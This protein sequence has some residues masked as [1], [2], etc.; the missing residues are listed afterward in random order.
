MHLRRAVLVSLLLSGFLAG[1]QVRAAGPS[2]KDFKPDPPDKWHVVS[3]DPA[4]TTSR[5][6]GNP[7]TPRCALETFFAC[8]VRLELALC[9]LVLPENEDF[10][11]AGR[12]RLK[13]VSSSSSSP[14]PKPPFPLL[15]TSSLQKR[16]MTHTP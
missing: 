9:R 10:Q 4:I 6:I 12:A 13:N 8:S 7:V 14:K 3:W 15:S 16:L 5:C 2:S 1:G 11:L